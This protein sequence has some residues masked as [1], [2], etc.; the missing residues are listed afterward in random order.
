MR[1]RLRKRAW[2]SC[3]G[4]ILADRSATGTPMYLRR[5]RARLRRTRSGMAPNTGIRVRPSTNANAVSV[6]N[7][8]KIERVGDALPGSPQRA[9]RVT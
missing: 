6:L 2:T 3:M 1:S 7:A 4:Q 8:A 9:R 5:R